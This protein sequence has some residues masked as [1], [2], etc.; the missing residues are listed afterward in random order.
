MNREKK[1]QIS[2]FIILGLILLL[3]AGTYLYMNSSKNQ[4]QGFINEKRSVIENYVTTCIS[5]TSEEALLLLGNQGGY[6]HIPQEI[7][8]NPS[9]FIALDSARLSIIPYWYYQ[10]KIRVPNINYMQEDIS[11]YVEENLPGC[12]DHFAALSKQYKFTELG[13]ATVKTRIADE[14]VII[15]VNFPFE[16]FD[17]KTETK[18][19]DKFTIS[20]DVKLKKM[21]ELAK[22]ILDY[23][24]ENAFFEN[25]TIDLMAMNND[26]PLSGMEFS[27]DRLAWP[28]LDV[29][30][31]VIQA[32][33]LNFPRIRFKNTKYMPFM[34]PEKDYAKKT[35][36]E[37]NYE[38][39]HFLITP[40]KNSYDDL[41]A[42]AIYYPEFGLDM[43][44]RPGPNNGVL[45]SN[46]GKGQDLF[47]YVCMQLYH[48]T[49]DLYFPVMISIR[50]NDAF[51]KNGFIFRFATPVMIDH[52]QASRQVVG[53]E[54]MI[55][56][57]KFDP[58][59]C[60]ERTQTEVDISATGSDGIYF[61]VELK[62]VN[63]TYR[64]VNIECPLG[65]TKNVEG[66]YKLRTTLPAACSNGFVI[67]E[68]PGYL[69]NEVQLTEDNVQIPLTRL[70]TLKLSF[71]VQQENSLGTD[72]ALAKDESIVFSLKAADS[73]YEQFG[74][75][76]LMTTNSTI[77]LIYDDVTYVMDATLIKDDKLVGGYKGNVTIRISDLDSA[78]E[79]TFGAVKSQIMPILDSEKFTLFAYLEGSAYQKSLN[80]IFK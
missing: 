56:P 49:Y 30:N 57:R 74:Y 13:N 78:R 42:S 20:F 15:D 66:V 6:V 36:L 22:E 8:N 24:N 39:K 41:S 72:R 50:D 9:S 21:T 3:S 2:L 73:K 28:F 16:A 37:D 48:F 35:G 79:V 44:A 58:Q 38:F 75:Y 19:F 61:G 60:K 1:A 63:M 12:I 4:G 76:D 7:S 45:E 53:F 59:F 27:C 43:V 31:S 25:I 55:P 29:K 52:N 69:S 62:D 68:K 71:R 47:R 17:Y 26:I 14:A 70:K 64:C 67:A 51:S 46:R 18:S 10:G 5:R 65:V 34:Y 33:N 32:V 40:S 77:D 11:K 54:E 23:E 80:P